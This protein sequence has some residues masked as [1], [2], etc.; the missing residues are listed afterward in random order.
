MITMRARNA[1]PEKIGAGSPAEQVLAHAQAG[2]EVIQEFISL[3]ES[4]N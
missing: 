1:P 4:L 2:R 3:P